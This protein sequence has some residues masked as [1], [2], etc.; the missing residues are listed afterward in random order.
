MGKSTVYPGQLKAWKNYTGR[1]EEENTHTPSLRVGEILH[2]TSIIDKTT[3]FTGKED[4]NNPKSAYE[5]RIQPPIHNS[6]EESSAWVKLESLMHENEK[7]FP[8]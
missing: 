8:A 1:T 6:A 7:Q 5:E 2:Q 4:R 3:T